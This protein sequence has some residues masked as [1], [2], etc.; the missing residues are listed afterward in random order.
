M[1]DLSD[2]PGKSVYNSANGGMLATPGEFFTNEQAKSFFKQRLRY[3]VGRYASS[4]AVFAW[5]FFNEGDITTGWTAASHALWVDDMARY[6]KSKDPY[7]H[8]I[9]TSLCCHDAP[10]VYSLPSVDF[11]MTHTYG[12]V[13]HT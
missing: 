2:L 5:E 7:N 12:A 8:P 13:N 3:L 4:P 1:S 11:S 9:S 6:L 10:Q